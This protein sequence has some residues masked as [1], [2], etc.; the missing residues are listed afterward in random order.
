MSS[1]I[2]LKKINNELVVPLQNHFEIDTRPILGSELFPE[3]YANIFLC[4][5]KK[6]GKTVVIQKILKSCVGKNTN[7]IAFCSTINKDSAWIAIKRWCNEKEIPFHY[8]PS[9]KEGKVDVLDRF[10]NKLQNEGEDEQLESEMKAKTKGLFDSDDEDEDDGESAE[11]E[12]YSEDEMDDIPMFGKKIKQPTE[13][14]T[15]LFD[16]RNSSSLKKKLPYQAPEF[17]LIFDDL[18]HELKLPSLVSL[19]KKNRHYKLKCIISSQYVNDLKPE[20]L[21]Q[22]DYYLCFKG[23][24][25]EKLEKL[26]TD[27]DLSVEFNTFD[28]LY[29]HA[30]GD[31]Y[32]FLYI[33]TRNDQFRKNFDKMYV[34]N[35]D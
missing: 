26:R 21:K 32:G 10:L 4:A 23:M 17:I 19:L 30:T 31:K 18:S 29:T 6:S 35:T 9:I 15:K 8:F 22:M 20:S 24:S 14:E 12:E 11:C 3:L 2:V 7:V 28:K 33:D 25:D 1:D 13:A 16:K 5:K 34:V 27:G